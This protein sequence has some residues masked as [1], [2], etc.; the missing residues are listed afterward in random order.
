MKRA[1]CPFCGKKNKAMAGEL[2]RACAACGQTD[3]V[4]PA[5]A[6]GIALLRD[7]H[8]LLS[9]RARAPKKGEWDL[10]GGF[11][12]RGETPEAAIAREVRE[13]TGRRLRDLRLVAHGAGTYGGPDRPTLN[14][15]ATG[16]IDGEPKA[17][18]DS[19]ELRW[20]PLDAV[21]SIAWPHEARFVKGL[22]R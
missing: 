10:V 21:P 13:E 11:I 17:G 7:G 8:V 3:W 16:T 14:F 6:I 5:P 4:N 20:W 15:L 1:F 22:R 12:D 9:K 2:H 18:D 19:E